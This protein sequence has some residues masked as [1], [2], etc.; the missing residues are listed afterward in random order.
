MPPVRIVFWLQKAIAAVDS[1]PL[2]ILA[3]T[4][5]DGSGE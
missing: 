2:Q 1:G 3:K 5:F 4:V